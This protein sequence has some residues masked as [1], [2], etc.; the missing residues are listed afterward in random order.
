MNREKTSVVICGAGPA[1]LTLAH[2]LGQQGVD[3]TLIEKLP[4]TVAEPRA[5]SIDG[6][7]LRTLQQIGMLAG[8]EGELLQ[9]QIAKYWNAEGVQL[10]Q[11]GRPEMKPYGYS[12]VNSFDQP[13]LDRYLAENLRLRESVQL[14]FHTTLNSF[15]Q[16]EDKVR[17]YCTDADGRR[18][19]IVA[20]YLVGADGGRSTVRSLLKIEMRGE[21]NPQP[22]LVIDTVDPYLD[23]QMGCHFYCDPARPGLTVPKRHGERRWEWM[24]MPGESRDEL[25]QDD[26]IRSIIAPYTDVD[27]VDIYRK[28]VY[29]FH[30]ILAERWREGRVFLVGD[31][32]H[33]TP[34]FAGQGL[35]SGIRDVA[36]LSWKLTAVVRDSALPVILDSYEAERRDHAREL[37]E[38][39]LNLGNQIQ[40]IDAVEAKQRDEFFAAMN[41][42]PAGM[43]ALEDELTKAILQ[44]SVGGSLVI[45][46]CGEG[47]VGRMM[48]QPRVRVPT[49][50]EVL[51]DELLGNSFSIV[52]YDC[53]P[54]D[55]VDRQALI[56]W[57]A[58]GASV[59]AISSTAG[60]VG[61]GWV[62]DET[63]QFGD[64][65]EGGR[66]R[67]LLVRPD[68]FCMVA[69]APGD[70]RE[71]LGEAY[72]R[73]YG[74]ARVGRSS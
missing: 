2:L 56:Q 44:R 61:A 48:V 39:A 46:Q 72:S 64:W 12:T 14:R 53:D 40:P 30:A 7:S 74:A 73:L 31:A 62:Y 34:P 60:R 43:Q 68:R 9:G 25:L 54:L 17:I 49:G 28:R 36:N 21:S 37:I 67:V 23:G 24:L 58:I 19:E 1:G 4:E 5:I 3:V 20:D 26:K 29:D 10:F 16:D 8:F 57:K 47:A 27:K 50:E 41:K 33:M 35:N 65:V 18:S 15:E 32:A 52:G 38:T 11:A 69:A 51:L 59:V 42:D 71:K 55:V 63:Q 13:A 70:A 22:W 6:E 66:P 45:S